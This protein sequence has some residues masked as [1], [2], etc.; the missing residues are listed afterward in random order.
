MQGAIT[1]MVTMA[2]ATVTMATVMGGITATTAIIIIA[3][4]TPR[5]T[6]M[7]I[8][9][10]ATAMGIAPHIMAGTDTIRAIRDIIQDIIPD[11]M[12]IGITITTIATAASEER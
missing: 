9:A 7:D 10:A 4:I 5:V 11:I 8:T 6:V 3:D 12:G 1:A 2:I